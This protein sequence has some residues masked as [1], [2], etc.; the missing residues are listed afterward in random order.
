MAV[1]SEY[2]FFWMHADKLS[3]S[4]CCLI[5]KSC[6]SCHSMDYSP[7]GFSVHGI[8]QARILEWVVISY[9]SNLPNPG[10]KPACPALADGFY[11]TEPAGKL[12]L[13]VRN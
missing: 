13:L 12:H 11:S 7:P 2:C 4:Y 3:I 9:S 5:A 10:I 6:L 8:S 1:F